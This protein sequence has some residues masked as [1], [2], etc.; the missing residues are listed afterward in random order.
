MLSYAYDQHKI[1]HKYA[2]RIRAHPRLS[3][4]FRVQR[5]FHVRGDRH[6]DGDS[7]IPDSPPVSRETYA[8]LRPSFIRLGTPLWRHVALHQHPDIFILRDTLFD[9]IFGSALVVS[10][11]RGKPLFKYIF[12]NVFAITDRGWSTLSLRW[13]I[14]FLI[15]ALINEW[16][17]LTLSP[18][19]WVVAKIMIIVVSSVF[20]TYQLTLT[21]RE[22]LPHATAWGVIV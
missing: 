5:G 7:H 2:L 21:R 14:F 22:R 3:G 10:V 8:D 6:D 13:G 20:G 17:R 15:L 1:T 16:V 12:S 18:E 4:G 11:W 9:G 19:D